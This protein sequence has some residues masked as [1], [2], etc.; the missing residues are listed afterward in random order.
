M[1]A[2]RLLTLVCALCMVFA[3][4]ARAA[5]DCGSVDAGAPCTGTSVTVVSPNASSWGKSPVIYPDATW[6]DSCDANGAS[7]TVYTFNCDGGACECGEYVSGDEDYYWVK[8][9]TG[10]DVHV[11]SIT[12]ATSGTGGSTRNGSMINPIVEGLEANKLGFDGRITDPAHTDS[13][14]KGDVFDLQA[15]DSAI[16]SV[17]RSDDW[18]TVRVGTQCDDHTP[19]GSYSTQG[20]CIHS[21]AVLTA[22]PSVPENAGSTVFRPPF[23]GAAT[24]YTGSVKPSF[25]ISTI[26]ENLLPNLPRS[27]I[28]RAEA[29][30]VSLTAGSVGPVNDWYF[31]NSLYNQVFSSWTQAGAYAQGKGEKINRSAVHLLMDYPIADKRQ[32]LY[33][34]MQWGIDLW[35]M[36]HMGGSWFPRGG[37]G[38][39]RMMP[40][41]FA[42]TMLGSGGTEIITWLHS[43]CDIPNTWRPGAPAKKLSGENHTCDPASFAEVG[44]LGWQDPAGMV[45]F[46]TWLN[47]R[48]YN[49]EA[50]AGDT[51]LCDEASYLESYNCLADTGNTCGARWCADPYGYIDGGDQPGYAYQGC[52]TTGLWVTASLMGFFIPQV[53]ANWIGDTMIYADRVWS[54][55]QPVGQGGLHTSPDPYDRS[56]E[57]R[58][59]T[60]VVYQQ[61][62][63]T[64]GNGGFLRPG[65]QLWAEYRDCIPNCAGQE[66]QPPL[67]SEV[68]GNL[69]VET[70]ESCDDGGTTSNDGCSATC[71]TESC[72]DSITQTSETCD[73]GNAVGGDGCSATCQTETC[74]N[75]V[76]DEGEGC[77]DGGTANGDGCDSLCVPE[78]CGDGTLDA[79]EECDDSNTTSGDG[80]SDVCITEYCGDSVVQAGLGEECD[81]GGTGDYDGCNSTC[82]DEV[83]GDG[84]AQGGIGET[85]DDGNLVSGDGCTSACRIEWAQGGEPPGTSVAEGAS[86]TGVSVG[87]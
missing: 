19:T 72:G 70:G 27:P 2:I 46:G 53:G 71:Q 76:L 13:Y 54:Y 64:K 25:S 82:Q 29:D 51:A 63:L 81:D 69:I 22:V 48:L 8:V 15:W 44:E 4:S 18:T 28:T 16:K 47:T 30:L 65:K 60:D 59:G 31:G 52:C 75:G 62:I 77:D 40:I 7:T 24:D 80:C 39:G 23:M 73:D 5:C 87:Q 36:G 85:C 45:L 11:T 56:E 67:G 42:G 12:P 3:W 20:P 55:N 57:Y 79:E 50:S 83:C 66:N 37:H 68:C 32:L 43:N 33:N 9:D 49:E 17:S 41:I 61:S 26:D 6:C 35:S 1:R 78:I 34:V 10:G 58:H 14:N 74:G 38:T 21:Y 86:M 84:I